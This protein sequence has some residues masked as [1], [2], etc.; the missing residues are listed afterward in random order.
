VS[1]ARRQAR[2]AALQALYAWE[3]GRTTPEAAVEIVLGGQYPDA[4]PAL[5][6]MA[7]EIVRGTVAAV[8]DLDRTIGEYSRHWRVE[9]L[10]VIDR[11]VLRM[12][13]WEL[14]Q[15]ERTPRRVVLNEALELARRFSSEDAVKFVNGVLDAVSRALDAGQTPAGDD[16]PNHHVQ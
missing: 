16:D 4:T 5:Q 2:E 6:A 7:G 1:D 10:A 13:I 15:P 9:R 12:A 14:Q 8:A 3:V 11:L